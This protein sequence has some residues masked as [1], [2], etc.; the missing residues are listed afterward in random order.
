MACNDQVLK[1]A[2]LII[3]VHSRFQRAVDRPGLQVITDYVSLHWSIIFGRTTVGNDGLNFRLIPIMTTD[4]WQKF[5]WQPPMEDDLQDEEANTI[6]E[7][8]K[9]SKQKVESSDSSAKIDRDSERKSITDEV[10]FTRLMSSVLIW[11][12]VST[13]CVV[14]CV[15]C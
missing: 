2:F 5:T 13:V 12:C 10:L 15:N 8:A 3:L 4:C 9:T 14:L 11:W 6:A 1:I 7:K